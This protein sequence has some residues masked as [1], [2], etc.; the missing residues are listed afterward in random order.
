LALLIAAG[1]VAACV[2][3]IVLPNHERE[4]RS[5]YRGPTA[6]APAPSAEVPDPAGR[7]GNRWL[8]GSG[9]VLLT[10]ASVFTLTGRR[11]RN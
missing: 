3:D 8:I 6:P 2:N 7:I 5:Q 11:P 1:P 10:A 9:A 4:F